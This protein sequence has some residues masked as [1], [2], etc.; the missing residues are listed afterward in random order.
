[1]TMTDTTRSKGKFE[2]LAANA[3]VFFV[4]VTLS[5]PF[6]L[7]AA[8]PPFVEERR[9]PTRSLPPPH[10]PGPPARVFF[11]SRGAATGIGNCDRCHMTGVTAGFCRKF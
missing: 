6:L 1:M 2:T 4:G 5:A 10:G 9:R 8:T 3:I 11:L 7:L